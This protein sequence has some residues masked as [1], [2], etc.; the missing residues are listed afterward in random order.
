MSITTLTRYSGGAPDAV[1]AAARKAKV[2]IE[3][4][5][6]E[7]Y[8]LSRIS[9]GQWAGQWMVASRYPDWVSYGNSQQALADNKAYQKLLAEVATIAKLEGRVVLVGVDL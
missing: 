6:A 7:M 1:I 4:A 8:R 9:T 2:H 5:G 3:K